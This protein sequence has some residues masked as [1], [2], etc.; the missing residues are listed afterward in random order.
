ML[1]PSFRQDPQL[2]LAAP[3]SVPATPRKIPRRDVPP[4]GELVRSARRTPMR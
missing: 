4:A 2:W 3:R 1:P